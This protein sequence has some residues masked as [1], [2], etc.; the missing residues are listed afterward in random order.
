MNTQA[1]LCRQRNPELA[2][3]VVSREEWI[4][5]RKEFLEKEKAFTRFRDQLSAERR[6][7]PWVKVGKRYVFDGPNGKVALDDLFDGRS[8]L[9]VYHFMLGPGWK[10]GCVGCSFLADHI[11]GALLHLVHHDVSLAVVSRAPLPEIEAFK[12][13]MAW[14]FTWVS[15][16]HSDFNFDYHVSFTKDRMTR[17]TTYYNYRARETRSEGE[18][19]GVSVFYRDSAG[20]IYHTYSSY[21]RGGDI[22]LGA[23]NYL[24]LTPKGRNETGPNYALTDWVRHHDRYH[25]GGF[26]DSTG[27][28]VPALED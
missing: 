12:R 21:A 20:N 1:T 13:R 28:Y 25:A 15:S 9:I 2:H 24:D 17:G 8:Q 16:F 11:G 4:A 6:K 14:S 23:Y 10:E 22:L 26:V 19:A 3:K 7:L 5:A 27:R 18:A